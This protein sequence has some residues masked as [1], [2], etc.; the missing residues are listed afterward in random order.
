MY[1]AIKY[2]GV[3]VVKERMLQ[4]PLESVNLDLW[5]RLTMQDLPVDPFFLRVAG[6]FSSEA[7]SV[8]NQPLSKKV[9]R[10][11]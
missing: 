11:C 9:V 10:I 3:V 5:I 4:H 7:K 8:F 6:L 2:G 1:L